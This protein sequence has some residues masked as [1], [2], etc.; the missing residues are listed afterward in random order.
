[1]KK[2]ALLFS[3]IFIAFNLSANTHIVNSGSYYFT[4]NSRFIIYFNIVLFAFTYWSG[5]RVNVYV[6]S[7]CS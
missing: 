7:Y 3:I 2:I 5:K 4:P 1:M 6:V